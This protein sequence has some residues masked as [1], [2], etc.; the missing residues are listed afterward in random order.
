MKGLSAWRILDWLRAENHTIS[1][2]KLVLDSA[3]KRAHSHAVWQKG[4]SSIDLWSVKLV[5]QKL[6]YV[7][8]NP[9]RAGLCEHS[10]DWQWSSFRAYLRH[11]EGSVPIEIDW[12]GYWKSGGGR[13]G[14]A[15][16]APKLS[17][18]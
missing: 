14:R 18:E 13:G 16:P 10:A 7:H 15:E 17:L 1:L 8:S 9:V 12:Q 6:H 11:E 3:Q 5:Q 2:A 4:F